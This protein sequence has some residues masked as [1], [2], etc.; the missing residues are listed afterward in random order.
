[1]IVTI[2]QPEFLP[3]IGFFQ[4]VLQSD[5][6]CF[7]DD[8]CFTKNNVQNRNRFL[9]ANNTRWAG[10]TV[11]KTSSRKIQDMEIVNW[12]NFTNKL[13]NW[14]GPTILDTI[15]ELL[16][17]WEEQKKL[18]RFNSALIVSTLNKLGYQGD[19]V[20]SSEQNISS[21]STQRLVDI[22][23]NLG[24]HCYL[25]GSGGRNYLD[26]NLFDESG[27]KLQYF[28]FFTELVKPFEAEGNYHLSFL[29][30]LHL[31]GLENFRSMCRAK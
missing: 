27:L 12:K 6:I 19:I 10:V 14:Y 1:M 4:K 3:Y 20:Y 13:V 7:L 29:H 23:F 30:Y 26:K 9:C 17:S 8:A 16:P 11:Q 5:A 24:G 31:Y 28:D 2:H 15:D 25:S 18:A 22:T 21:K